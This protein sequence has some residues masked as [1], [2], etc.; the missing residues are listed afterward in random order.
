M[1]S[2]S[3]NIHQQCPAERQWQHLHVTDCH[4]HENKGAGYAF[5]CRWFWCFPLFLTLAA[6]FS[7]R[8]WTRQRGRV[9]HLIQRRVDPVFVRGVCLPNCNTNFHQFRSTKADWAYL[10]SSPAVMKLVWWKSENFAVSQEPLIFQSGIRILEG[11]FGVVNENTISRRWHS[12]V[13]RA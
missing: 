6:V 2:A 1:E 12:H 4:G 11:L 3:T 13:A 9:I 10:H 7:I 5:V 8:G